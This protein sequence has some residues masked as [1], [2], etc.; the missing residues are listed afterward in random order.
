MWIF[1][2]RGFSWNSKQKKSH[3][4]EC[5]VNDLVDA[6]VS[7]PEDNRAGHELSL[8]GLGWRGVE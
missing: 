6:E 4:L 1:L 2:H 5:V 3:L 7:H 8:V